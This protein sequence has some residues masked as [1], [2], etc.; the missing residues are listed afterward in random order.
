[1]L[2]ALLLKFPWLSV[3]GKGINAT[4]KFLFR[5]VKVPVI[6]VVAAVA[7][8]L[9]AGLSVNS[10]TKEVAK[11]EAEISRLEGKLTECKEVSAKN[12]EAVYV[13]QRKLIECVGDNAV[14]DQ[15]QQEMTKV[16]NAYIAAMQKQINQM[17]EERNAIY[18]THQSCSVHRSQPV[19][20][21]LDERLRKLGSGPH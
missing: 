10:L 17:R 8:A 2:Q 6:V 16:A 12:V 20:A 4:V 21:A 18:Q 3:V 14:T 1:M 7:W 5:W 11:A 9:W 19:C 15:A 13:L